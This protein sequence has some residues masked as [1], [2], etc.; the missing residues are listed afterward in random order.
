MKV[1]LIAIALAALAALLVIQLSETAEAPTNGVEVTNFPN[2]QNVAG[3][4]EVTNFPNPQNV[5]G[6]VEV[7]NLPAVQEVTVTNEPLLVTSVPPGRLQLIG[8][9]IATL[10]GNAG[11]FGMTLACQGEFPG[12]RFCRAVEINS[13]VTVP[14]SLTG[15]G[16]FMLT[17]NAD[18][19]GCA[20]FSAI[21]SQGRTV[22]AMGRY[23]VDSCAIQHPVACCAR[24]P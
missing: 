19:M 2:P 3:S 11:V 9:T 23:S 4:V 8:F 7:T 13:T 5:E 14:S 15:E 12:S 22:D 1:L 21:A 17:D 20:G 24:V 10:R 6:S 18:S 16:W